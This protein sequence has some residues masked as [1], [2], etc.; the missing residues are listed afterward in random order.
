MLLERKDV[1]PDQ[2]DTEYGQ[3]PLLWAASNRHEGI[4]KMLLERKDVNPNQPDT[5]YGRTPLL[6][7]ASGGYEGMVKM[8]LER[9][10]VNPDQ[11]DTKYGRTPLSLAAEGGH[12]RV[13]NMFLQL[14]VV[15][16]DMAEDE[17]QGPPPPPPPKR[18]DRAIDIIL[19]PG[20]IDS[21]AAGSGG[22]ASLP[23]P[24]QPQVECLAETHIWSHNPNTDIT[25]FGTQP[26][27]SQADSDEP[28]QVLNL[29]DSVSAFR[30]NDLP[31][32]GPSMPPQAASLWPPRIF[33]FTLWKSDTRP[34][35]T[36]PTL[37]IVLNWYWI[38]SSCVCLLAL[39]AYSKNSNNLISR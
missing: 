37:P 23:P 36:T 27:L 6:W 4:V 8:L 11:P 10:D 22:S 26:L 34:R 38:I 13:V 39:L 35:N 33:P 2:P 24:N 7:A 16:A 31:A 14:K 15:R 5:E 17:S 30:D 1:N 9:K 12:Q 20:N 28:E 21:K 19:E 32:N 29:A 18:Y 3:T 25:D